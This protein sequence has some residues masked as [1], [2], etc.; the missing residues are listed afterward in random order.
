METPETAAR[1][2]VKGQE[3]QLG[4]HGQRLGF[5]VRRLHHLL[6]QRVVEAFAPYGLLPWSETGVMGLKLDKD[7]GA[8]GTT[9]MPESAESRIAR[10]A[11]LKMTDDGTLSGKVEVTFSGLEALSRGAAGV[12][13]VEQAQAAERPV[14]II[15]EFLE[16]PEAGR[17][18]LVR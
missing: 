9:T 6:S 15:L 11:D 16:F 8:W 3:L 4:L 14:L 17:L 7:G 12:V 10:K 13:F 18:S 1:D 2:D 5:R